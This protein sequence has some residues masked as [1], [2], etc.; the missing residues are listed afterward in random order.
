MLSPITIGF[1]AFLFAAFTYINR[2]L[3]GAMLQAGDVTVLNQVTVFRNIE[4]FGMFSIPV[5][6]LS[7]ITEGIPHLIKWDYSFFGGNAGLFQYLMY[8]IT[9]AVAFG[10]FALIV[11]IL[12]GIFNR[13]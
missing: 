1:L 5:P 3:E 10:L 4:V 7:F 8:S 2:V 13:R 12:F 6:N 11:G 9:A